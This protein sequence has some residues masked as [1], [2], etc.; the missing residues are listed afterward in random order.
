MPNSSQIQIHTTCKPFTS[1]FQRK[2]YSLQRLFQLARTNTCY[3]GGLSIA[4]GSKVIHLDLLAGSCIVS[5]APMHLCEA[6]VRVAFPI[7]LKAVITMSRP[8][9]SKVRL[10]HREG[11]ST[12]S[13]FTQGNVHTF[14]MISQGA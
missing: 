2:C 10:S 5:A 8:S 1:D 13:A 6:G 7:Q 3:L 11:Q 9:Q 12:F 14:L 4:L